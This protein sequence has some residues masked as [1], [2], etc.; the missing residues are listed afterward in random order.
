MSSAGRSVIIPTAGR[1]RVARTKPGRTTP[2]TGTVAMLTLT[3]LALL[4]LPPAADPVEAD[5]V[6]RGVTLYDGAGQPGR[7]GDLAVRGER[8]VAVGSFAV[9]GQPRVIDGGGL[10]A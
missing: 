2:D 3:T 1:P 4:L 7:K 5:V 9:A 8:I 10:V 6:I